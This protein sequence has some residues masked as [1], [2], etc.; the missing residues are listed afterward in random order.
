MKSNEITKDDYLESVKESIDLDYKLIKFYKDNGISSYMNFALAKRH[1]MQAHLK[2]DY[3][4]EYG[5]P[6]S[7][8]FQAAPKNISEQ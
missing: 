3:N 5:L 7:S 1:L 4:M 2:K 8:L 6:N